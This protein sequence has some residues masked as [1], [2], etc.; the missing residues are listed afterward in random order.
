MF[1]NIAQPISLPPYWLTNVE[2]VKEIGDITQMSTADA[3]NVPCACPMKM[4]WAS[5]NSWW[6]LPIEP[7]VAISCSNEIAKRSVLKAG[8]ADADRRGT[9]KELWIQNDYDVNISGVLIS[10]EA[11]TLPESDLRRLRAYCEGRESVEVESALFT[12]FNIRRIA[13]EDYQF[14]FTKGMENQMY[15]IKATSD[16]FDD[17][18]LLI[19]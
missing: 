7:V 18:K 16:D 9:V 2:V 14:P 6:Q 11:N 1:I 5:E 4:K 12:L 8:Y 10:D 3:L 19:V 13:I 15:T 17:K